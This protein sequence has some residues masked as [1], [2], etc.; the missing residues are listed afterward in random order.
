MTQCPKVDNPVQINCTIKG[1]RDIERKEVYL[2][3]L[4]KEHQKYSAYL[5]IAVPGRFGNGELVQ[6]EI[7]LKYEILLNFV[8]RNN[9]RYTYSILAKPVSFG[10]LLP[11]KKKK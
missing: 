2:R 8:E 3:I 9:K 5:L 6:R 1:R 4:N 11:I 10:G 7:N